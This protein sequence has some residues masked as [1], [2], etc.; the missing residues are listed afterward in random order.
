MQKDILVFLGPPGS[1]KGSQATLVHE[2]FNIPHISTGN[3]LR[4][5]IAAGSPLG[6]KA[7][8][9]LDAGRLTPD[10]LITDILL[11]RIDQ[12]D[13]ADGYILDGYP[14]RVSQAKAFEEHLM[15]KMDRVAILNFEI[16]DELI[17]ERLSKRLI[18]KQCG[19]PYHL[20]YSPPQKEGI[21]DRC[22]GELYQ[23][24]DDTES[25]I[26]KRLEIY[27]QETAPLIEFYQ[28]RLI[29]ID[30]S[31]SKEAIFQEILKNIA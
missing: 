8:A 2:Q 10:T 17:I 7:K 31:Q 21:C 12:P 11:K 26:R 25:V 6:E 20:K 15:T 29:L 13:C 28:N 9:F 22:G 3:L 27:K 5:E 19:E 14:R 23:R 1:G 24:S 16:S 4:S 18:C 30:C